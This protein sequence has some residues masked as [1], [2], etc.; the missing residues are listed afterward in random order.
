MR[1]YKLK[2]LTDERTHPHFL[3][4]VLE[5]QIWCASPDAL[6]DK[7]EFRI[8]L[9]YEPSPRTHYL[10]SQVVA[11]YRTTSFLPPHLSTSLVLENDRLRAIMSRSVDDIIEKCRRGVGVTSFSMTKADDDLWKEYGGKGNGACIEIDIPDHLIGQSYHHVRYVSEKVFHVDTFLESTLFPD[12]AF[13]NFQN[14]LLTKTKKWEQEAEIRFI[15]R[16]QN[17]NLRLDGEIR[18]VTF[19][20]EVPAEVRARITL[21]IADHCGANNIKISNM[22]SPT[23][24]TRNGVKL[25]KRGLTKR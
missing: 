10:L 19:G 3:Q 25:G 15:G 18:E 22:P 16:Q 1:I 8:I 17:V 6:N 12:R 11:Q 21:R 24:N 7:D 4:I 9:D 13:Q 23:N 2:D 14:I 20:P 5:K